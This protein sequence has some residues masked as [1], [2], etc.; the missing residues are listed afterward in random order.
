MFIRQRM[1]SLSRAYSLP[2]SNRLMRG[3]V[4]RSLSTKSLNKKFVRD[5]QVQY[6]SFYC[7]LQQFQPE[8]YIQVGLYGWRKKLAFFLLLII[9]I[10]GI[11]N[12][13]ISYFIITTFN[14]NWVS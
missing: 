1:A 14:V 13:F 2:A 6:D 5:Q 8:L 10:L 12:A 9:T 11:I 4:D 3:K 7:K